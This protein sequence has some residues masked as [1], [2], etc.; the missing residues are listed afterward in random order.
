MNGALIYVR[1]STEEQ[2]QNLSLPTQEKACLEYCQRHDFVVDR[3]FKEEGESAKTINR[4]QFQKLLAYC[5]E[6]K[7]RI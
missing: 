3:I 5:R 7:G 1:V 2:T 6:N 4:P